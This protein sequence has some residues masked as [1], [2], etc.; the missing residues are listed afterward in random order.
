MQE[1]RTV[2][3]ALVEMLHNLRD[4]VRSG[5]PNVT[6]QMMGF[7]I[8]IHSFL[9]PFPLFDKRQGSQVCPC[10]LAHQVNLVRIPSVARSVSKRPIDPFHDILQ[11]VWHT[12]LRVV[13]VIQAGH[14][15]PLIGQQLT[16]SRTPSLV[17]DDPRSTRHKNHN[18]RLPFFS[19]D[20]GE[21]Q[22][23]SVPRHLAVRYIP[24][25]PLGSEIEA[26]HVQESREH[27]KSVQHELQELL[28]P[29]PSEPDLPG[30]LAGHSVV[31]GHFFPRPMCAFCEVFSEASAPAPANVRKF[32]F[33]YVGVFP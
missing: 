20:P 10:R 33:S 14:N 18:R 7:P 29:L 28:Q 24:F 9:D 32:V 15:E 16:Y 8:H 22:V 3:S 2:Q 1:E 31:E 30:Q 4:V 6:L 26:H 13:P 25:Y 23:Q 19:P 11:H 12:A 27:E 17:P 5:D 21:I